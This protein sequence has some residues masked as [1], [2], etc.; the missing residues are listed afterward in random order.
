[1]FDELSLYGKGESAKCK[2]HIK[3]E[4]LTTS[5]AFDKKNLDVESVLRT[6]LRLST[7][8]CRTPEPA[9]NEVAPKPVF[10]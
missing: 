3:A 10:R 1:M 6:K 2:Q 8:R 4:E 9:G 7:P 5:K